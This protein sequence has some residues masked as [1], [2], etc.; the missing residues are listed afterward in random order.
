MSYATTTKNKQAD[1]EENACAG[2]LGL[3][4]GNTGVLER[5]PSNLE[6]H[7]VLRVGARGLTRRDAKKLG[8]K[9]VWITNKAPPLGAN[10]AAV[11]VSMDV[12]SVR[13]DLAN[14][15]HSLCQQIPKLLGRV[16]VARE[17]QP[18]ADNGNGLLLGLYAQNKH[19]SEQRGRCGQ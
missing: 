13:R 1:T 9:Q 7:A 5:S 15:I 8:L 11:I 3:F 10:L 2:A 16:G 6:K 19:A 18:H 12:P 14:G 4:N 17:A